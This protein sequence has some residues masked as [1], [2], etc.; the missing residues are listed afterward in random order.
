MKVKLSLSTQLADAITFLRECEKEY[1][2]YFDKVGEQEKKQ[3]DLLHFL[4]LDDANYSDRCKTAT[5]LRHCLL[6][7][8]YY[9]DR[10]EERA[11]IA[12]FLA[13]PQNKKLLDSL[14]RVLGE[15]RR[16]ERYHTNRSYTPRVLHRKASSSEDLT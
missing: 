15:V 9:K 2:Y 8:R 10:V 5:Q 6:E 7:R 16:A 1:Q 11:P 13:D 14:G 12:E 3:N 4:E